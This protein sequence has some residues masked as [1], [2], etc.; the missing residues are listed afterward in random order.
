DDVHARVTRAFREFA[1]PAWQAGHPECGPIVR[2][3]AQGSVAAVADRIWGALG[4]L[5]P[6]TFPATRG[7][8]H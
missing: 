5:L 4:T 7:S 3:D 6:E 2:I 1:L 8:Q